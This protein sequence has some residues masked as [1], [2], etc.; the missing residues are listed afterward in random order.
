MY[1]YH[2][3]AESIEGIMDCLVL[4]DTDEAAFEQ[5]E[6]LLDKHQ[7]GRSSYPLW[8]VEKKRAVKGAGYVVARKS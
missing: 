7:L 4:A 2:V 3:E 1:L 8:I 6:A 5:A